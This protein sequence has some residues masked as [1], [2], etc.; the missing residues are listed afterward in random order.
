[1]R[2]LNDSFE[3]NIIQTHKII[4][5]TIRPEIFGEIW[6]SFAD[7]SSLVTIYPDR[8]LSKNLPSLCSWL[9]CVMAQIICKNISDKIF[10]LTQGHKRDRVQSQLTNDIWICFLVMLWVLTSSRLWMSKLSKVLAFRLE[11]K[12]KTFSTYFTFKHFHICGGNS[13]KYSEVFFCIWIFGICLYSIFIKYIQY[14][15]VYLK[16]T[17]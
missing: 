1:M 15:I 5:V 8:Y 13:H 4:N 10:D 12:S 2:K 16:Y 7:T 6:K 9:E 17:L 3:E 14:I 11:N